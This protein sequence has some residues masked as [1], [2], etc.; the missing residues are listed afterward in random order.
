MARAPSSLQRMPARFIRSWTRCLAPPSTAPLATGSPRL[1]NMGYCQRALCEQIVAAGA[2]YVVIV[3]GNQP[4]LQQD[5]LLL[6]E[7]PPPADPRPLGDREPTALRA[8]CQL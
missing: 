8:G 5:I 2:D 1:R 4:R 3:K 7:S 6:F